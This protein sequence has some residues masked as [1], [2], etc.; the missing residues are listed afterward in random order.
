MSFETGELL[1]AGPVG[2][3]MQS[4]LYSPRAGEDDA[5]DVSRVGWAG[6]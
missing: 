2:T 5:P 3:I 4:W 6:R 1:V